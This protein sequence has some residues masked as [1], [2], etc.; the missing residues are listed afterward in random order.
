MSVW[1]S[2]PVRCAVL[3]TLLA[4]AFEVVDGVTGVEEISGGV[5]AVEAVI[6]NST[7]TPN[8]DRASLAL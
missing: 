6:E 8:V 3:L 2:L 4:G 5:N 1:T 7:V